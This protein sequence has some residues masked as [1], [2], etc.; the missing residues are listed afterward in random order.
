M[1]YESEK[2]MLFAFLSRIDYNQDWKEVEH[3]I[4]YDLGDYAFNDISPDKI[5]RIARLIHTELRDHK[6]LMIADESD[7][8]VECK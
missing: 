5:V 7:D 4:S 2:E 3:E 8:S 6:Q 1:K